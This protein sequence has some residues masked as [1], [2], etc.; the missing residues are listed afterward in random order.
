MKIIQIIIISFLCF[1]LAFADDN[2]E[3]LYENK[4]LILCAGIEPNPDSHMFSA[5]PIYAI[6][7][8][9]G[10][11]FFIENEANAKAVKN[12]TKVSD[13]L[14]FYKAYRGGNHPIAINRHVL[15]VIDGDQIINAGG[16]SG[17]EDIDSDGVMDFYTFK[18]IGYGGAS[19]VGEQYKKVKLILK[20]NN[21]VVPKK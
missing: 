2:C 20:G 15:I 7:K 17:Y 3:I 9:T 14:Y 8:K 4:R 12:I 1:S 19:Y 16:F 21:L 11:R 18:S 13:V 5:H 6:N 10:K